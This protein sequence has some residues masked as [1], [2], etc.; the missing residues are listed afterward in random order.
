MRKKGNA[1]V[2]LKYLMAQKKIRDLIFKKSV[3]L[4]V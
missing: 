1:Q 2:S 3:L 4:P